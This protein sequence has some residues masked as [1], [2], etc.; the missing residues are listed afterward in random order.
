M[1]N[2]KRLFV[3]CTST[4][5]FWM[6]RILL[7][8]ISRLWEIQIIKKLLS[9]LYDQWILSTTSGVFCLFLYSRKKC[10]FDSNI[11]EY[12]FQIRCLICG[13]YK[14]NF[15]QNEYWHEWASLITT[16]MPFNYTLTYINQTHRFVLRGTFSTLKINLLLFK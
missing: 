6:I 10:S 3:T 16:V 15:N 7:H 4:A 5:S 1:H 9:G 13:V 12:F 14:S 11:V 8:I 2:R